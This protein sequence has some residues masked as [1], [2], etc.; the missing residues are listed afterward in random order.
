MDIHESPVTLCVY[1]SDCAVD[2]IGAL[3]LVGSKQRRQGFSDKVC[4]ILNSQMID[5]LELAYNGW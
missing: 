1:I 5:I 4:L 2:L 3:T